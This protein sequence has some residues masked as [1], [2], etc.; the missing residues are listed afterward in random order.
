MRSR[1]VTHV[2]RPKRAP[3]KKA[4]AA[5][6]TNPA[7]VTATSK[8][9]RFRHRE[10]ADDNTEASP[11]IKAFFLPQRSHTMRRN[12]DGNARRGSSSAS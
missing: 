2:H 10:A 9:D 11:E 5:A 3:R 12:H 4:K 1:I 8:R 6:I 7:I